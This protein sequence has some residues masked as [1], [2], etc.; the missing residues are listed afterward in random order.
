MTDREMGIREARPDLGDLVMAAKMN[1]AVTYLTRYGDRW[2]AIVPLDR[3][4]P[5]VEETTYT[6][7]VADD[8]AAPVLLGSLAGARPAPRGADGDTW[9]EQLRMEVRRYADHTVEA[10]ATVWTDGQET[11]PRHIEYT[12]E[13]QDA[14]AEDWI[15]E[16][17]ENGGWTE[18]VN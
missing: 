1:G 15:A 5:D 6:R 17:L 8:D 10:W 7:T 9:T 16:Y 13:H 12:T 2:A 4:T 18:A 11:S 3:V 14:D